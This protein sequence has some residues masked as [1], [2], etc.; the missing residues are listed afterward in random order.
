MATF[1]T[2]MYLLSQ[3]GNALDNWR[4]PTVSEMTNLFQI[5]TRSIPDKMLFEADVFVKMPAVGNE[6]GDRFEEAVDSSL[7]RK[8]ELAKAMGKKPPTREEVAQKLRDFA[9]NYKGKKFR[10]REWF[11]GRHFY[12]VDEVDMDYHERL[13]SGVFREK[14]QR[15]LDAEKITEA[16]MKE[17][18][19]ADEAWLQGFNSGKYDDTKVEIGDTD[20]LKGTTHPD[21]TSFHVSRN[22]HP[23]EGFVSASTTR[24]KVDPKYHLWKARMLEPELGFPLIFY[25]AKKRRRN[26][27]EI[28]GSVKFQRR[29]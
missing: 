27:S 7:K 3:T 18:L 23:E 26:V 15:D 28:E 24:Q 22:I 13:V 2:S 4:K 6:K 16:I 10:V 29:F 9:A 5:T 20:F 17:V 11:S 19:A 12:R 14:Y 1:V 21:V 25:F 8:T